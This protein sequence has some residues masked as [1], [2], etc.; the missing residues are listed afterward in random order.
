M[1]AIERSE[2]RVRRKLVLKQIYGIEMKNCRRCPN[3]NSTDHTYCNTCPIPAQLHKLGEQ[4]VNFAKRD[5]VEGKTVELKRRKILSADEIIAGIAKHGNAARF[6]RY[7]EVP[8]STLRNRLI[9]LGLQGLKK[10]E[11]QEI[12]LRKRKKE[13]TA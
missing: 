10:S 7:L 5:E 13:V 8:E 4:L 2:R 3:R 11:A 9:V 12:M 6:A 1:N